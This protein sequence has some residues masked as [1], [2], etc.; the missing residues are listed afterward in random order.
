MT[1][2]EPREGYFKFTPRMVGH[3]DFP[4]SVLDSLNLWRSRL[5]DLKLIGMY[6]TGDLKGVGYGNISV[7][8]P[9]GFVITATRTGS[10]P[11]LGPEHYTEIVNVDLAR[12]AVDFKAQSQGASPSSEC[13][14]HA[15]F[16]E[17]DAKVGAVVH[18]HHRVFW[19]RLLDRVPTTLPDIA[20]G[21]PEMAG[22]ILRLYKH[23]DLPVRKLLVMAGHEEGIMA[24]GRDL[25]EAGAI[26][27]AAFIG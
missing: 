19:E 26:L 25:D 20:Y 17:A 13:M 12:N 23:S 15:M 24:F 16:Y 11:A 22:E 7:R 6:S 10:I 4:L 5:Y 21:T 14:T 2:S 8:T 27:L 18:V 3:Q 9:G 1:N